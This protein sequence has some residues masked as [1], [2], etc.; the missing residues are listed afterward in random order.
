MP[1]REDVISEFSGRLPAQ[2]GLEVDGVVLRAAAESICLTFD[3]CGGPGGSGIDEELINT[4]VETATPATLFLNSRWMDANPQFTLDLMASDLFEVANHGSLHVP[5]SVTGREAY[6]IA[7]TASVGEVYDEIAENQALMTSLSGTPPTFFRSGTAHFDEVAAQIV[8]RL[9]LIPVNFDINAD[10]GATFSA[11]QVRTAT[12]AARPGSIC[13]GHFN[14]PG[15]G[16]AA[17]IRQAI[18]DLR[19]R[20]AIFTKL[21]EVA[22]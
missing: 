12:S 20:G 6:G 5:L 2:W 7:G 22:L 1:S 19:S 3:A 14:R 17:G 13:I 9:G 16:T 8:R 15:S 18:D 4:L 10:A 21:G 11:A